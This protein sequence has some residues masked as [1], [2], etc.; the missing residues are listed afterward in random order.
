MTHPGD[1]STPTF[2]YTDGNNPYYLFYHTDERFNTTSFTRYGNHQIQRIDYPNGAYETFTY[3]EFG[4]VL[5]HRLTSGGVETFQYDEGISPPRGLLTSYVPPPT[6]TDP[7]PGSHPTRYHYNA[8]D[9][10]D[11]ITDPRG[12]TTDLVYNARGQPSRLARSHR[13]N[14]TGKVTAEAYRAAL[15]RRRRTEC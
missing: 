9:R 1:S 5:T 11:S 13:D 2:G 6:D 8:L 14:P 7:D 4:R 15:C 3:N 12:N 10:V